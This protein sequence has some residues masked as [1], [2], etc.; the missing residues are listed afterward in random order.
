M[1]EL[2]AFPKLFDE[3]TQLTKIISQVG[4]THDDPFAPDV[5]DRVKVSAT[6]PAPGR[7][8]H[9]TAML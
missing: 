3:R 1:N 8:E 7:A 5:R 9:F 6:K 4:V 2:R